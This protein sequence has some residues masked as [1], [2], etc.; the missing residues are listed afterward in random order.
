LPTAAAVVVV[1]L[2]VVVLAGDAFAADPKKTFNQRCTACHSFGK[3]VKVGPDLKGVTARRQRPWLLKFIRSSQTV[4]ASGDPTAKD[5][6]RQFG[7][8]RMPDWV[9]L[10]PAEINALLDWLA[11]D[12]PEQKEPDE[13]D[14]ALATAAHV[15]RAR[16]LF[17]GKAKLA[18]GGVACSACHSLRDGAR[19]GG[20]LGPDLTHAYAKYRDRALTLYLKRPCSPRQPEMSA[21][22]YLTPEEAFAIKGYL[23]QVALA[24]AG[25]ANRKGQPR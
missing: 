20:T 2:A 16:A 25:P 6:F 8:Q 17:D 7:K 10:S 14:A 13:Q 5:L 22:R 15:D 21:R 4:I 12:G 18:S 23:R 9:D 24:D 1:I 11:A 3:G 19:R